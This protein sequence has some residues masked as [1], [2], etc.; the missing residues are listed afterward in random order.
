MDLLISRFWYPKFQTHPMCI[1]FII[2]DVQLQ[3]NPSNEIQH[4]LSLFG[5]CINMGRLVLWKKDK[6][7][8]NC[9]PDYLHGMFK[10]KEVDI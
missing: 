9:G 5:L 3:T 10:I 7:N 6:V 4:R 1:G 8:E 2:M